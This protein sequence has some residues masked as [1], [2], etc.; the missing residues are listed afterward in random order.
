M[1]KKPIPSL[2]ATLAQDTINR[3]ERAAELRLDDA[4]KLLRAKRHL[5]ALYLAGFGAEMCLAAA[6]YRASGFSPSSPISR[7]TRQREMAKARQHGLMDSDPH[8]IVGWA[9]F[10]E[11]KRSATVKPTPQEIERM[12]DAIR[13]A[14]TVYKHWRPELRYK[15][16]AVTAE[17]LAEVIKASTW[18][19]E[20]RGRL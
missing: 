15:T 2:A 11:W 9:R 6:C 18:F 16:I 20:H 14:Q 8:P 19:V 1:A 3:L 17:Q 4:Q 13:K 5:S 12:R 10:L 7:Q